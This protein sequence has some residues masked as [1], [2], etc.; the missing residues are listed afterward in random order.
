MLRVHNLPLKI[1]LTSELRRVRRVIVIVAT[2][3][4]QKVAAHFHHMS[5]LLNTHNPATRLTRPIGCDQ[6]GLVL[7]MIMH[8][9]LRNGLA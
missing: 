7:N 9:V 3:H 5:L 4:H 2:A 8:F 1:L 6:L